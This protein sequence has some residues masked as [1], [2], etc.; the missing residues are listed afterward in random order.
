MAVVV[1]DS[2]DFPLL[3]RNTKTYSIPGYNVHSPE[4]IYPKLAN[5]LTMVVGLE[6]RIW[7]GHDLGD[8]SEFNN[9]GMVCVD[10]FGLYE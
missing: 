10:V 4:I 5:P 2:A 3:P 7:F 9:K 1:T 6:Y 8:S